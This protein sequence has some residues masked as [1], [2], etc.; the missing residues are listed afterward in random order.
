MGIQINSD[1]FPD[2]GPIPVKYT[3]DGDNVSPPLRWENIPMGTK[4][5]ALIVEDPDAPTPE[6]FIHWVAFKIPADVSKLPEGVPQR[7]KP[8]I[9]PPLAQGKNDFKDIGYDGPEPPR[10][11]GVHHYHFELYALDKPLEIEPGQDV[12]SLI[13]SMSGHILDRGEIIGTYER[14]RA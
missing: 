3:R 9:S 7:G 4:E 6:P 12:K 13:A 11:H 14:P 2:G 8:R 1:A 10:G 5:L